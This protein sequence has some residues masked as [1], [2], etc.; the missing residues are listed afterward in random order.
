MAITVHFVNK[1]WKFT[2][3]LLDCFKYYDRH[4]ADNL[5]NELVRIIDQWDMTEKV[6]TIVIDNAYNITAAVRLTG[7]IHLPCLSHT[8]NLVIQDAI[9][10]ISSIQK[11][12]KNIVEHFHKSTVAAEKLREFQR[13]F[14]GK[15]LKLKNDVVTRWN[16]TYY[17]FQRVSILQNSLTAALGVLHNPIETLT[18]EEWDILK[19]F[20]DLLKPFE[21]ITVE[22]S[23]ETNVTVSK[24]IPMTAGLVQSVSKMKATS[25]V[26]KNVQQGL[27]QGLEKQFNRIQFS[28]V[29][30]KA[31]YLD[32][33]FKKKGFS[34]PEAIN[35]VKELL[36]TEMAAISPEKPDEHDKD[37]DNNRPEP[38][39]HEDDLIW[40]DFDTKVCSYSQFYF[41]LH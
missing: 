29:L 24:V 39:S 9:K 20:C 7:W 22:L 2:S 14:N 31:T 19:E 15:T 3:I 26:A 30:A 4:T 17:M 21:Q 28:S 25:D 34:D 5:K 27:L 1:Y 35:R 18:Q 10:L 23:S 16:S 8:I 11:K 12:V 38:I 41:K 37:K 13:L 33:R 40:G 36:I 6:H 32:P